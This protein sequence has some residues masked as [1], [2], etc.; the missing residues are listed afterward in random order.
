MK[1]SIFISVIVFSLVFVGF[2]TSFGQEE[3]T[4]VVCDWDNEKISDSQFL[5]GIEDGIENKTFLIFEF[6]QSDKYDPNQ[7]IPDSVKNTVSL[8]CQGKAGG[9][10]L[11][12]AIRLLFDEGLL[13]VDVH[14]VLKVEK[15]NYDRPYYETTNVKLFGQLQDKI[16][17]DK[18]IFRVTYPDGHTEELSVIPSKDGYF[19][20][21]LII[22][23][24]SS[25]GTY[26]VSAYDDLGAYLGS[27]KYDIFDKE[28]SQEKDDETKEP[29]PRIPDWVKNTMGWYADGLISEND[30]ILAIKFLIQEGIIKLD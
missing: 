15:K 13:K 20:N 22:D 3:S 10:D 11:E 18:I 24:K 8:Y 25:L 29:K 12:N 4:D 2:S 17:V 21:Y 9:I 14:N 7:S 6:V 5:S 23:R 26:I 28:Q 30:I 1:T 19:E 27:V 16:P